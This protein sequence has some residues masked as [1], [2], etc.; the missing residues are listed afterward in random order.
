[1]KRIKIK[2][3]KVLRYWQVYLFLLLPVAYLFIFCYWPMAGVQIAFRN[4]TLAGGVWGSEFVGLAQFQKFFSSYTFQRVLRN[5][6]V[7]S[8]Y[9]I[10]A[11]F[12]IPIIFA[13]LLNSLRRGKF[14]KFVQTVTYIPHFISVV[15]LVGMILKIFNYR[16][17]LYGTIY[18]AITGALPSDILA[19]P[20]AFPHIYV[21][22]GIWQSFGWDSIL[23]LAALTGISQE[24]HEAAQIDGASR[25]KRLLHIDLPGILPTIT[26]MLILNAGKVMSIGFEKAYLLQNQLNISTSEIISTYVYKIGLGGAASIPDYSYS[27]A[28]SL[29][30][31]VINLILICA[32]NA[33]SKRLSETS[34]W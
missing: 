13:L 10:M 25:F 23:Y 5:T 30:N 20:S 18:S 6:L 33:I 32:V 27:T 8:A 7:L 15:V 9:N 28:I 16:T 19:S 2:T 26:I 4:F 14:S 1:M 29:F 34:L 12:P 11:K 24:L 3:K 31:S 21:L 22:S 17:G